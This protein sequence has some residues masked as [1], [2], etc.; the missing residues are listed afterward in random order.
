MTTMNWRAK[1]EQK[2]EHLADFFVPRG[3]LA[4]IKELTASM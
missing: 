2:F 3:F 4:F 1:I